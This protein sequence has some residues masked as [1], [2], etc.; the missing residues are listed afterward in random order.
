M[1]KILLVDFAF[2]G[3]HGGGHSEFYLMKILSI[4]SSN[5]Y[6][7]YL[8]TANNN[9]LK[10][11]IELEK[12]ENCGILD[13]KLKIIDKI[14]RRFLLGIDL[15]FSKLNLLKYTRFASLIN[16]MSVKRLITDLGENIPVFLAHTDSMMPAVPTFISRFFMP[17]RWI[18]LC[19]LPSYQSKLQFGLKQSRLTFNAEKNF[20]LPSCKAVFVLHP[21]Y[22]IFFNK[23]FKNLHCLYL[24]EFLVFHQ[25][26]SNF[27]GINEGLLKQIQEEAKGKKIISMLGNITPRKNLTLFLESVAKIN[28]SKCF[29]VVLGKLKEKGEA[30]Y[31]QKIEKI[32]YYKHL[33][34]NNFYIDTDY[35]ISNEKEFCA[36]IQLSDILFLHYDKHPFSSNILVKA[37]AYKKPAL[38]SKGYLM[39]STVNRYN[40]KTATESNPKAI[41]QAIEKLINSSFKIDESNYLE[42]MHVHSSEQITSTILQACKTLQE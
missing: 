1:Q 32:N 37:M 22:Q 3:S 14:A 10:E 21:L 40:W 4:L 36:L 16:L 25:F 31:K 24:A 35:F 28:P 15:F 5:G 17:N 8:C 41:S 38:V 33:L 11:N 26:H 6:Y 42:F 34:D 13:L 9:Q 2:V 7:V 39:E 23:R 12:I 20:A 19:I 27:E 30:E 29:I 18:G